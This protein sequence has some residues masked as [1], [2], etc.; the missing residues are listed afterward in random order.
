MHVQTERYYGVSTPSRSIDAVGQSIE[1]LAWLGYTIIESV[2][3]SAELEAW[4]RRIDAVYAAQEAE[5]GGREQL[6]SIGE[7]DMCRAPLLYDREFAQMA[8]DETVLAIVRRMI[9][10]FVIL[11]LQNAIIN[12]PDEAH[13]QSAWHRDLPYQNWTISKPLAI[14]A[15]FT[16]DRFDEET[17]GTLFLPHSHRTD[18]IPSEAFVRKHAVQVTAEPGS[19]ILFDAMTFHRAGYNRSSQVRRGV[20][21][22]YTVPIVKQQYDFPRA[23]GEHVDFAPATRALLG[24]TCAVASDAL[25]WRKDRL[26]RLSPKASDHDPR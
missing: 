8:Q 19:V 3:P 21:H 11:N 20:N 9:G 14:G 18:E 4:R 23:L 13:H 17:G 16:I 6:A 25:Q 5:F 1:E 24:Y 22:L 10:D 15:L 26:K 12:R 7:A 2:V